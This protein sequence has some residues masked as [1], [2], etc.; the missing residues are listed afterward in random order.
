M[1]SKPFLT[2]QVIAGL[3]KIREQ[4]ACGWIGRLDLQAVKL[5]REFQEAEPELKVFVDA[6]ATRAPTTRGEAGE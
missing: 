2:T 4:T 5:G 6:H 3:P 1:L